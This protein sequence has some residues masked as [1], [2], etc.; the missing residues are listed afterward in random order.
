M[1]RLKAIYQEQL[2]SIYGVDGI[3]FP[4]SLFWL[5][6]F[7]LSL[8]ADERGSFWDSLLNLVPIGPIEWLLK[9]AQG[10]AINVANSRSWDYW[11]L[12]NHY[13][14]DLPEFLTCCTTDTAGEHWGLLIDDPAL[15]FR[16]VATFYNGE[17]WPITVYDSILHAISCRFDDAIEA[18]KQWI[19][20]DFDVETY[21][22]CLDAAQIWK[23]RFAG[24]MADNGLSLDDG[25][26]AGIDDKTGLSIV[27]VDRLN[28]EQN[29]RAIALLAEARSLWYWDTS[30]EEEN[31][32]R[33]KQARELMQ[34][35]YELM[36]RPKLIEILNVFYE[37]RLQMI[38]YR[39]SKKRQ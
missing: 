4:D 5:G 22:E 7:V 20:D 11:W 8:S 1:N 24:F 15:G 30:S 21:T 2:R 19:E 13:Y 31:L 35:A 10:D 26:P 27:P 14:M 33:T 9:L 28:A 18:Y 37:E 16:G 29:Q 39:Q 36:E 38:A 25:R 3:E 6:D 34:A 23:T 17:P 32:A 12:N